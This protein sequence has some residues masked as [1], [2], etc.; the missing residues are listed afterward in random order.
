MKELETMQEIARFSKESV[1][2]AKELYGEDVKTVEFTMIQ[3]YSN[4]QAIILTVGKND[5]GERVTNVNVKNAVTILPKIEATLD[6]Y[7]VK[8]ESN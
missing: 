6:I 8:E 3:P 2:L 1:E 5:E 4:G 7:E